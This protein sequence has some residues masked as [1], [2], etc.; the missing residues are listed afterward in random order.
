MIPGYTRHSPSALNLFC[1]QPAMFVLE[2]VLGLRQPVG[3][4]AHRGTAVEAGV[5]FGLLNPHAPLV[6]CVDIA[7]TKY[8][9]ITAL[10]TDDRRDKYRTNLS[11]MIEQAL[12]ELRPYGIPS[13]CQGEI[14]WQP[15][16]LKLPIYG[17]FDF[18]W[19]E[20]N[21]TTDLKTSEKMPSSVKVNHAKQV[22]FYV[23]SN[24]AAAR[25]TYVTPKKCQTLVVENID[26]H[27]AA[28]YQI[29]RNVEKFLS[30]S[31]DPQFFVDITMPDLD[32]FY[33]SAPAARQLAYEHWKI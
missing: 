26:A 15:E 11:D 2:R 4:P 29:A 16:G 7:Q 3:V 17:L 9:T 10:S 33:W 18:H 21:I 23:T 30:L 28:L 13:A 25:I 6:D 14:T 22:S 1:A 20:H 24:N 19:A 12:A 31:D 8:D 32:S 27:R 5:A